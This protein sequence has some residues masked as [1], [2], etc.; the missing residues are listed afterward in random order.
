MEQTQIKEKEMEQEQKKKREMIFKKNKK[1]FRGYFETAEFDEPIVILLRRNNRAEF[2]EDQTSGKFKYTHSSGEEREIPLPQ[3][4]MITFPYGN[5]TFKG[6]ILHEDYGTPLPEDPVVVAELFQISTDKTLNDIKK[7]KTDEIKAT[8]NM[9]KNILY[10]I[11]LIGGVYVLYRLLVPTPAP[12][13]VEQ[14]VVQTVVNS[15]Q[16]IPTPTIIN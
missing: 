15:T 8:G 10:G 5:K 9:Y 7:W 11:A 16:F 1:V 3:K 13:V 2:I 12:A 4:S 6:F 14:A